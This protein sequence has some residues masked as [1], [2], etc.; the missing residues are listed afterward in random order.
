[1]PLLLGLMV[2]SKNVQSME[3]V[4]PAQKKFSIESEATFDSSWLQVRV[5]VNDHRIDFNTL[6]SSMIC[7]EV[8]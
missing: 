7:Y 6:S 5:Y 3:T 8:L 2:F 1:M 4:V